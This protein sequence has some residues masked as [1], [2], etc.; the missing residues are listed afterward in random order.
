MLIYNSGDT[1]SIYKRSNK[2]RSTNICCKSMKRST[3]TST[4]SAAK[5][6]TKE[7]L[8]YLKSLGLKIKRKK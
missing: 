8:E 2:S 4:T 1:T 5:K 6:L 7:N 3:S